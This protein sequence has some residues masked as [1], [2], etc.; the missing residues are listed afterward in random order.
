MS[1]QAFQETPTGEQAISTLIN[2]LAVMPDLLEDLVASIPPEVIEFRRIPSRWSI[3]ENVC[4][5]AETQDMIYDRLVTFKN[6]DYPFFEPF[7]PGETNSEE[8]LKDM[9]LIKCL[10]HFRKVRARQIELAKTFKPEDWYKKASHPQ[11]KQ[12]DTKILLR[13]ILMHD[14]FHMYRVEELWLTHERFLPRK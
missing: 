6:A 9:N 3:H 11:Y 2:Q 12:Y 1:T 5:L 14:H 13:H 4:H 10:R 8:H 7:L